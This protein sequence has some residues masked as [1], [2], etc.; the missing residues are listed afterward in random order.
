MNAT[1][2]EAAATETL[3]VRPAT[4]SDRD[5]WEA[6]V[7]A[8]PEATFFH[9]FGWRRVVEEGLRHRTRFLLAERDGA[10]AGVLPLAQ[11]RSLLFGHNLVSLPCCVYGGVAA[12]DPDAVRALT[13][14]ACRLAQDLGVDALEMRNLAPREPNWPRKD[15]YVTFR[16]EITADPEAN[17]KAIPRKQRAVVRKAIQAGLAAR[18]VQDLDRFFGI[19]AASVRNL[20][21]PVFP[22]KYF[23]LLSEEFGPDCE[24]AVVSHA[25]QDIASVMSF[26]FRDQVLPYYGG[27]LPAA[28]GVGGNDFMYWDLMSRAGARGVRLFDYGRSKQ[29]AG[30]YSFKKNWGFEPQPLHYEYHLV[31]A[32]EVPQV[33]PNNP[34]YHYFIE[35]WKRLPLAVANAI[36][37]FLARNLG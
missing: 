7:A 26:Y 27:S 23:R 36:G 31:R 28:R 11:V 20:G 24:L 2:A 13:D 17:M 18:Q 9:R 6:F 19:Y 10:L 12:T 14:A 29:G 35:T 5:R 4:D 33:N 3:R 1:E 30:S 34:K 15:L 32:K 25:G 16:K 8:C 21:T 22:R 37:P